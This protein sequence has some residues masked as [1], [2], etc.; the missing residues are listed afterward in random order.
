MAQR[1]ET[2]NPGSKQV[3]VM[4]IGLEE[5]I[6][7]HSTDLLNKLL[8]DEFTLY[9]KARKYHWN[10]SGPMFNDLHSFF[11]MLY[12]E[13]NLIVD[14]VAERVKQLGGNAEGTMSEYKDRTTIEEDPGVYKS[15]RDMIEGM[16]IGY[17]SII[18]GIRNNLGETEEH[19]DEGTA[20]FLVDIM[21]KHE[22]KAWMLRSLL[23]GW[24]Q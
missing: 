11:E 3:T 8:S 23:Q 5:D 21:L 16:L 19:K 12:E 9:L 10:V 2:K 13:L 7:R 20:H 4:Q 14:E 15:D 18:K 17:E 24:K 1:G 22:K 6:R